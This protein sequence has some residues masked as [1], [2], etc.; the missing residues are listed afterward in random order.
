[1]LYSL[2]VILLSSLKLLLLMD[3]QLKS[4]F[5]LVDVEAFVVG[6]LLLLLLYKDKGTFFGLLEDAL[7]IK[8]TYLLAKIRWKVT[9]GG[10]F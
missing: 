10:G 4:T 8:R 9:I 5:A 6:R 2:W 1:M 3:N 7:F